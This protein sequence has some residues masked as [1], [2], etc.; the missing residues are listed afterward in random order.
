VEAAETGPKKAKRS[1]IMTSLIPSSTV[2]LVDGKPMVS[3]RD[4][5]LRFQRK[6]KHILDEIKRIST[7]CP[8]SFTEPNFRPSEYDDSTGRT[9]PCYNL[10][11]DAFSLLAMGFTGK[12]A[13]MWKLQYIE[14]FNALEA[15]AL[16]ALRGQVATAISEGA[17]RALALSPLE[18]SRISKVLAYKKRGFT[19]REMAKLM[20][21]HQ[22]SV[23]A[24]LK[25][26]RQLGL[27]V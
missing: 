26:A 19:Q 23:Y 9:L 1:F 3:S 20:N 16:D 22:R 12:A 6:H 14:A 25:T 10:T 11:R 18:K 5:A 17:A 21:L 8:K 13:I 4:V 2:S 27:G 24:L 7:M 15:A